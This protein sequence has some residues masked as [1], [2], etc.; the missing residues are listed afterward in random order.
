MLRIREF[1]KSSAFSIVIAFSNFLTLV[2]VLYRGL[3]K[4]KE[5]VGLD[6]VAGD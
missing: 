5:R 4:D 6:H 3:G 2:G 1:P